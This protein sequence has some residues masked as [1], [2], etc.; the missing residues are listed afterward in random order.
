[1]LGDDP[2]AWIKG[3]LKVIKQPLNGGTRFRQLLLRDLVEPSFNAPPV[4]ARQ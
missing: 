4:T 3:L 1:M 2:W